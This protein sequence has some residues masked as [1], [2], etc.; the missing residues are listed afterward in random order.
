ME[1]GELRRGELLFAGEIIPLTAPPGEDDGHGFLHPPYT[2]GQRKEALLKCL[3]T[4]Y[5]SCA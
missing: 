1:A 3:Y 5:A 2:T 4:E